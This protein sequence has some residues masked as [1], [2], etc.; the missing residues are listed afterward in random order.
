VWI[1]IKLNTHSNVDG[2][3]DKV[4]GEAE[5]PSSSCA[6]LAPLTSDPDEYAMT[7]DFNESF[8]EWI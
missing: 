5:L 8:S 4:D 7:L 3:E 6:T 2:S 1:N